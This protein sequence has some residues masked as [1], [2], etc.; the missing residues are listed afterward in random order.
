[1]R[2]SRIG[3]S[4]MGMARVAAVLAALAASGG[5]ALLYAPPAAADALLKTTTTAHASMSKDGKAMLLTA[6][7]KAGNLNDGLGF[8]PSGLIVF[9]TD[10]GQGLA[11]APMNCLLKTC[12][13]SFVAPLN[14][15]FP[16]WSFNKINVFYRGDRFTRPSQTTITSVSY[17][18]CPPDDTLPPCQ[19]FVAGSTRGMGIEFV[20]P[21]GDTALV[22]TGGPRLPCSTGSSDVMNIA[23][24]GNEGEVASYIYDDAPADANLNYATKDPSAGHSMYRCE[25]STTAFAGFNPTAGNGWTRSGSDF[26]TFG[27]A[28]PAPGGSFPGEY[29]ALLA[30]CSYVDAA[31][32]GQGDCQD[33][34]TGRFGNPGAVARV[35]TPARDGIV[36][37]GG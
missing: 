27:P 31:L 16:V 20:V 34:Q 4:K 30:D 6:T 26:A 29:T 14:P 28:V 5:S 35:L 7:V 11:D 22:T 25:S 3:R 33:D 9:M 18:D 2:E 21:P 24:S 8:T 15:G 37:I 23:I 13:V 32:G 17:I 1:M 19:T 12:T 36:R 10:T